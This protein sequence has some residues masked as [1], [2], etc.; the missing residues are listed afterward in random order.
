MEQFALYVPFWEGQEK[1]SVSEFLKKRSDMLLDKLQAKERKRPKT[2]LPSEKEKAA[3]NSD[4]FRSLTRHSSAN[5]FKRE[6]EGRPLLVKNNSKDYLRKYREQELTK[7]KQLHDS[8]EKNKID[9]EYN[10]L[11]KMSELNTINKERENR[12]TYRAYKCAEGV[13]KVR[14]FN[15]NKF[16]KEISLNE[17]DTIY[18]NYKKT[19]KENKEWTVTS[20]ANPHKN[21][22]ELQKLKNRNMQKSERQ[23]ELK[24]LLV[25]TVN[26]TNLLKE[27]IKIFKEKGILGN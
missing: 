11:L 4:H 5:R 21:T 1:D 12:T 23:Q 15:F 6:S 16:E 24:N 26:L 19:T 7:E 18:K 22:D 10:M 2:G 17:F 27:Q 20:Q 14:V 8:I 13:I 25:G 3:H 9:Q